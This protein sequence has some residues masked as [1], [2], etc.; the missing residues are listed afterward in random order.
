MGEL[1]S[2][3]GRRKK[4]VTPAIETDTDQVDSVLSMM[5]DVLLGGTIE[6]TSLGALYDESRILIAG[7]SFRDVIKGAN[8]EKVRLAY[9]LLFKSR[10][11][12]IKGNISEVDRSNALR[13]LYEFT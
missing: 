5:S 4:A 8:D 10:L 6:I 11:N 12:F 2:F 3:S 1:V 13:T 7:D 9:K